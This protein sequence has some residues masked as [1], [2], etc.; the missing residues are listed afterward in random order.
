MDQSLI[1]DLTD[2]HRIFYPASAQYIFFSAAHET[3]SKIYH[4]LRCKAVLANTRKLK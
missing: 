1:T 4:N 2:I 3:L